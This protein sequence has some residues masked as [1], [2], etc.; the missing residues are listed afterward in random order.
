M[1]W[2]RRWASRL[3]VTELAYCALRPTPARIVDNIPPFLLQ[4]GIA[5]RLR[6]LGQ[7][8]DEQDSSEQDSNERGAS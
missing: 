8:G 5:K 4:E 6:A 7:G 2:R 1:S 3:T